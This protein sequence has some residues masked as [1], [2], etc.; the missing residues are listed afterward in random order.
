MAPQ[1]AW[2]QIRDGIG[3]GFPLAVSYFILAW[4]LGHYGVTTLGFT[5][6]YVSLQ[7]VLMFSAQAQL[8][9]LKTLSGGGSMVLA[10]LLALFINA[11]FMLMAASLAPHFRG[12][13]LMVLAVL[14]HVVGNGPFATAVRRFSVTGGQPLFFG[15][16][17]FVGY[18]GYCLGAGAGAFLGTALP[19]GIEKAAS[20]ALP[21]FLITMVVTGIRVGGRSMAGLAATTA[22]VTMAVAVAAGADIALLLGPMIAAT[23][24]VWR[25]RGRS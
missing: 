15:V 6:G 8:A 17:G 5:P 12:R 4:S 9:A 2:M 25:G 1:S 11:R 16:T 21:A 20:F 22:A 3:D 24:I 10:I 18:A 19:A 14:S 23:W 13:P 7:S